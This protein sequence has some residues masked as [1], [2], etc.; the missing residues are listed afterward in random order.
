M[1]CDGMEGRVMAYAIHPT[2]VRD[3]A[4]A[5][6]VCCAVNRHVVRG[7]C[8]VQEERII[9]RTEA[10]LIE[11]CA[12]RE[13]ILQALEYNAAVLTNFWSELA[14]GA[15]GLPTELSID[16]MQSRFGI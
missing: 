6:E 7:S 16:V 8:F 11:A 9:F 4:A 10:E 12:A 5:L 2:P 3:R 13:A 14:Q 15:N 1:V